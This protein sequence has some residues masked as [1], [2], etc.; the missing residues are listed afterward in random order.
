MMLLLLIGTVPVTVFSQDATGAKTGTISDI[1]TTAAKTVDSLTVSKD[2]TISAVN[3]SVNK[4]AAAVTS[5]GNA[6][7]HN[8]I[9]IN[10]M[11]TLIS[12]LSCNVYAGGFCIG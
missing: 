7:G 4:L 2:T 5:I 3:S 11:W 12:R 9:A 6:D 8:K 1:D 10:I